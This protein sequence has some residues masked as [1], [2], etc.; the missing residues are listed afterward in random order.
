MFLVTGAT[1]GLG[2]RIIRILTETEMSVRAFVRLNSTYSELE[3][4]GAEVFIGDLKIDKDILI[5]RQTILKMVCKIIPH[6]S[7]TWKTSLKNI[8][9]RIDNYTS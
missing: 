9:C 4:C 5:E 8:F 6:S 1:G 3:N 2:R 7:F